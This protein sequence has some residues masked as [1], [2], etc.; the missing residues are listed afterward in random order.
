MTYNKKI[1]KILIFIAVIGFV[2]IVGYIIGIPMVKLANEPEK[3]RLWVKSL[4]AWGNVVFV[5]ILIFQIIF[6][7][8]PGEPF[9]IVAGYA[10]GAFKGT[11]LCIIATIIGSTIVFLLVRFWGRRFVELFFSVE[12]INDLVFL[13]DSKKRDLLAFV[14]YMMPGTPK[15][16]LGY[17]YGLTNIKFI[18]FFVI[19]AVGRFPSVVTSTFGGSALGTK[20]YTLAVIVFSITVFVSFIGYIIYCVISKHKKSRNKNKNM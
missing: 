13:K 14:I 18:T 7:V 3:F 15:D 4:G 2:S 9:E 10:F 12:K 6:A 17:F 11:V 20:N 5:G 19:V 1:I 8:I 16:L